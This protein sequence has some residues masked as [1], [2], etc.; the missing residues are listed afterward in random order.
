MKKILCILLCICFAFSIVSCS[1]QEEAEETAAPD[2]NSNIELVRDGVS[3]YKIVYPSLSRTED[4]TAVFTL[5]D[6]FKEATGIELSAENDMKHGFDPEQSNTH[7][8]LIG[9]TNYAESAE[10]FEGLRHQEYKVEVRETNIVIAAFTSS[11]YNAAIEWLKKE[12][13][14]NFADGALTMGTDMSCHESIV[15]GYQVKSWTI[16]G[17]SLQK[18]RIVYSDKEHGKEL[19]KIVEKIAIRTGYYLDL[20]LDSESQPTQYE[21]LIGDTNRSE[22]SDLDVSD[23]LHYAFKTVNGK[24]VIKSGGRHS[25]LKRLEELVDIITKEASVITM[26]ESYL[27]EGNFLDETYDVSMADGADIRIMS[28][29][30]MAQRDMYADAAIAAGFDF[31][32]RAEIFFSSLEF[33]NPTVVGMQEC[34]LKW[35]DAIKNYRYYDERWQLV[36]FDNPLVSE[37]DPDDKVYS[38]IMFRKDLYELVG[39]GMH[40]YSQYGN[41]RCRN[42]TWVLL[43]DRT[44]EQ[45]FCFVST[46][47]D[48]GPDK[49]TDYERTVLQGEELTSFVNYM[50][51]DYPVFTVGDFNRSET[52]PTY[53]KYL[54]DTGAVDCKHAAKEL[55][56]PHLNSGHDWGQTY[57]WSIS[58]DHITATQKTAEVLRFE[59]L[60]YNEQIWASDHSWLIADIKFK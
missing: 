25:Y 40:Y 57:R 60:M 13:F 35:R 38:S 54:E 47:W 51:L 34:C 49:T 4:T 9:K 21:I 58:I 37:G 19:V 3:Q 5:I 29:N 59:T 31:E 6:T 7:R 18:F 24:L 14:D 1:P 32:R 48:G 12:V 44:T 11:G 33:Y 17:V 39:S 36:E 8:I 53:K 50:A 10:A 2:N 41:I 56:N 45:E 23:A 46:H 42:Y 26:T 22:S 27:L 30:L 55:V 15:S 20:V 28:A 43:R 52:T 16:D